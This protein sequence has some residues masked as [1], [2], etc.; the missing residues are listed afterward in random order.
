MIDVVDD[1]TYELL[2]INQCLTENSFF[3]AQS[4]KATEGRLTPSSAA[5]G[6]LTSPSPAF[7]MSTMLPFSPPIV[8]RLSSL[9]KGTPK[10]E[11]EE[12]WS[13][14]AIKV[15]KLALGKPCL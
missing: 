5:A 15:R 9:Q 12:K 10:N 3:Q 14:K 2:L 11:A 6:E 4:T 13:E 8:K 7:G 1:F